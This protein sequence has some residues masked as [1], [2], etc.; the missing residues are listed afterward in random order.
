MTL[1]CKWVGN[2]SG[3]EYEKIE[4]QEIKAC[5]CTLTMWFI[6]CG[7]WFG[8]NVTQGHTG[9]CESTYADFNSLLNDGQGM[10]AMQCNQFL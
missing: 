1:N 5:I 9:N 3:L 6:I 7:S 4:I 8:S 2:A 10:A